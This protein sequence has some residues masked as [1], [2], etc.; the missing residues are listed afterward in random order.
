[1]GTRRFFAFLGIA[2]FLWLAASLVSYL[3]ASDFFLGPL[4]DRWSATLIQSFFIGL[5]A[6]LLWKGHSAWKQHRAGLAVCFLAFLSCVY[7]LNLWPAMLAAFGDPPWEGALI[8]IPYSA[9]TPYM[10]ATYSWRYG[11]SVNL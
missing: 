4:R 7:L 3:G 1:M 5:L 10:W 11:P 9:A 6:F 2:L 8:R